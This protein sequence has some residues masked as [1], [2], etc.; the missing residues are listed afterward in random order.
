METT[1]SWKFST[2]SAE[3]WKDMLASCEGAEETIDLEQFVFGPGS[4]DIVQEFLGIL[5]RKAK[6]GV[7]IR[8]L[9]DAVGSFSF[10]KSKLPEEL[11]ESGIDVVFHRAVLSPSFKRFFPL[12]LRDHRKLLVIDS[13]EIHIG[14]VIIEERARKW[15][16]TSVMLRGALVASCCEIFTKTYNRA[17]RMKPVGQVLSEK[18]QG[19]FYLAGNSFR[20][21][22]KILYHAMVHAIVEAKQTVY[23]TTPYFSPPKNLRR[24][25]YFAKSRGADVRIL[26]PKRS[27]N[28]ISD[29]VGRFFYRKLLRRGIRIFQ[30]TDAILH[31]KTMTVDSTWSTVG[32]CNLDWLSIWVNYELNVISTNR[33]FTTELQSHF[34]TDLENA[35]EVTLKTSL[36][37]NLIGM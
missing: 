25:L 17:K 9:L 19:E 23:I 5:K 20:L 18:V 21:K 28:L 24:A 35:E 16:D 30:Y 29:I 27:D 3:A 12:L 2:T 6:E 4:E 7:K 11:R 36:F 31:A 15:R 26:L 34:K 1:N 37:R 10:F 14:G 32:S 33:D 22:D 13:K 8:L